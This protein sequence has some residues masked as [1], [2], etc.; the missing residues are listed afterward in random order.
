MK[1]FKLNFKQKQIKNKEKPFK[2][3]RRFYSC[4][5]TYSVHRRSTFTHLIGLFP[6]YK[7]PHLRKIACFEKWRDME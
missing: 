6:T 2:V 3:S 7:E 4:D 1:Y 5:T